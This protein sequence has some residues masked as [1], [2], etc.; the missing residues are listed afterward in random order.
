MERIIRKLEK[1]VGL[2][3]TKVWGAMEKIEGVGNSIDGHM[4]LVNAEVNKAINK[5]VTFVNEKVSIPFTES[6]GDLNKRIEQVEKSGA[7]FGGMM[8]TGVRSDQQAGRAE[9][10]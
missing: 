4:E 3:T 6:I 8:G 2:N 1:N 9:Y 10:R 7:H 5:I